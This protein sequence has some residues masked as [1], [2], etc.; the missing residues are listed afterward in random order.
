VRWFEGDLDRPETIAEAM[1][2]VE[3]VFHA[4][5]HYPSDARGVHEH[6]AYGVDQTRTVIDAC[7][8]ASVARLIYTSSLTTIGQAPSDEQRLAD[9]RDLYVPGSL[10]HSAYYEC[11]YAMESEVLRAT[12]AGLPALVLNPTAVFGPGDHHLTTGRALLAVARGWGRA[13]V[14]AEINVVDVREVGQ[15][16]VRAAETGRI[17]ERTILGGHNISVRDL[18]RIAAE[19]AG[20][21]PPRVRIPLSLIDFI[22]A[23]ADS[24]PA[25]VSLG[26]HLRALRLWQGYNCEKAREEFGLSPRPLRETLRDALV[27]YREHGFLP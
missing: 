4:A 20:F 5:G 2:G 12:A 21:P 9:E 14:E 15:A 26:N 24:I 23:L 10:R 19:I 22:V 6:V 1:R 17:G 27:W 16:H 11:K 7:R 8:A 18:I 3:V 13:W 25:P